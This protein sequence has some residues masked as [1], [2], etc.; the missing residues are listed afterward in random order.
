MT[1]II[2]SLLLIFLSIPSFAQE[3][4]KVNIIELYDKIPAPPADVKAARARAECT[5]EGVTLNCTAEK[6]FKP[7]EESTE[8]L[9]RQFGELG[10][11]LAQPQAD[12]MR[13]VDPEEMKKK[14][15]SMTQEEQIAYAMEMSKQM[16][17]TKALEP[18]PEAVQAALEECDALNLAIAGDAQNIMEI[19]KK[20]MALR[21]QRD[22][23]HQEISE[24]EAAEAKKIPLVDGG[25]AGKFPDPK[26]SYSLRVKTMDKHIAAENEYL[27]A[28]PAEWN[29]HL[30]SEKARY[31]P[32]QGKLVAIHYGEDAKNVE[33]KQKLVNGQ[34]QLLGPIGELMSVSKEATDSALNWW[35]QKEEVVA[36]KPAE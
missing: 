36:Q 6:F 18:E 12:A 16:G 3:M 5:G 29:D 11:A 22:R 32:L 19:T 17:L 23:K 10:M 13:K 21:E 7:T 20:K 15:E 9:A 33:T 31:S 25:E 27:K 35:R 4:I 26:L 14:L 1:R 24:W 2:S 8:A 30:K 28:L 34:S